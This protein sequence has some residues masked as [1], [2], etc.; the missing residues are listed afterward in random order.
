MQ[1]SRAQE[2]EGAICPLGFPLQLGFHSDV[3]T[4]MLTSQAVE[5]SDTKFA[6]AS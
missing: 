1:V 3:L 4:G 6:E 2:V 5:D